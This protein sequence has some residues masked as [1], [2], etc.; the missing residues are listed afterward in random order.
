MFQIPGSGLFRKSLLL[1][2]HSV[3]LFELLDLRRSL[4]YY[5]SLFLSLSLALSV[6]VPLLYVHLDVHVS[7]LL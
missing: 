3:R 1:P 4:C 6:V 2:D 7:V 5:S